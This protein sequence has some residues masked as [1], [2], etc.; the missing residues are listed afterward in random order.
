MEIRKLVRSATAKRSLLTSV[1]TLITGGLGAVFYFVLARLLGSQQYGGL[2]LAV[3]TA[4]LIS[5]VMNLGTDQSLVKFIPHYRTDSQKKQ[6]IMKLV[7]EIKTISG[8]IVMLVMVIFARG[9]ADSLLRQP[10][11]AGLLPL[12]GVG[13]LAQLWFSFSVSLSQAEEKFWWWSGLFVL[14]NLARLAVVAGLFFWGGLTQYSAATAYFLIPL[15][16]FALF[17]LFGDTSFIKVRGENQ[18]AGE[19]WHFNKWVTAFLI[20]AATGSRLD[21]F[22]TARLM[23]LSSVGLYA[24]ATQI[25]TILPQL[26]SAIGTVTSPRF[27][28]FVSLEENIGYTKK[29][30]GLVA[31]T[32]LAAGTALVPIGWLVFKFSAD[33]YLAAVPA[34]LVLIMAMVVFLLSSPLRDSLLYYF[35]KSQFFVWQGLGHIMVVVATSYSLIPRFGIVGSAGTVLLGQVFIA[36]TS[37]WYYL[38]LVRH[39]GR[40]GTIR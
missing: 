30:V 5:D 26:T 9:I 21:T 12:V 31:A 28:S 29:A 38:F 25:V 16:A 1:S 33:R 14:S 37:L 24:L 36:A 4:T 19:L 7:L 35:G 10:H 39:Q 15:A 20:I 11:L 6:R 32:A 23:D 3:T 8:I 17:W 2:A 40:I 27:A 34:F 22:I 18:V 13:V